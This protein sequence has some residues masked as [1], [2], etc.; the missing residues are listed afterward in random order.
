ML[1]FFR[2]NHLAVPHSANNDYCQTHCSVLK[3]IPYQRVPKEKKKLQGKFPVTGRHTQD[4]MVIATAA[5][6]LSTS[7]QQNPC[8]STASEGQIPDVSIPKHS[9]ALLTNNRSGILCNSCHQ[10]P[11]RDTSWSHI[12]YFA[13]KKTQAHR[14]RA[15][16]AA[17]SPQQSVSHLSQKEVI[18]Q[19]RP[20]PD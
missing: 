17:F 9:S 19:S 16:R 5:T 6:N 13:G 14:A 7:C 4:T 2:L 1:I 15:R 18:L 10:G 8:K 20:F 3:F 11:W 12:L